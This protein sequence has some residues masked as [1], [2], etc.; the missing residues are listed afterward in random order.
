MKGGVVLESI[1]TL[2]LSIVA[3]I[4]SSLAIYIIKRHFI[5]KEQVDKQAREEREKENIL[6][7]RSIN[8]IGKLTLANSIALK[9]GKVNGEMSS[10]LKEY[11][12]VEKE[13]YNYLLEVNSKIHL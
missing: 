4:I 1:V 6:I 11:E 2:V 13:L 12:K 8:A 7:L 9:D 3:T 5:K 10:A